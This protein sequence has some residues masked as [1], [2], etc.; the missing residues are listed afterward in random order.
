MASPKSSHKPAVLSIAGFDPSSGAGVTADIKT[1][2]SHKCYGISCITAL[3]VQSTRGVLRV[4]P[5][6]GRIITETL[7][8]LAVDFDI[9]AV[10][11]GMLGS[12]EVAW[13]VA[14]FLK[15]HRLK[16]VVLDPILKSSSGAE[17]ISKDGLALL[18][19]RL[20]LRATVI[21]PNIAEAAA[22]TEMEVSNSEQMNEAA[23]RLQRMGA[24]NVV[25]TGGHLDPPL[26][27][28]AQKGRAAV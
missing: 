7:E 24:A 15:R 9:A 20:L 22:L 26:D 3:T 19:E 23:L 21:T 8:E 6:E 17:M 13:A 2:T 27:L 4:D 12:A 1:I 28:V 16:H 10:K 14:A 11:I 5:I 18:K 25:I